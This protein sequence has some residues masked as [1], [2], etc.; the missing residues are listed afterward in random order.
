MEEELEELE[1]DI[2]VKIFSSGPGVFSR[3]NLPRIKNGT[4]VI[5]LKDVLKI[6]MAEEISLEFRLRKTD[7]TRNY[8]LDE[9]KHNNLM[10][11][12]YRNTCKYLNYVEHFLIIASTVT[13]CV[14]ISAFASLVCVPVGIT[15]SAVEINVSSITAG[16]KRYKPI[17]KKRKKKHDKIV[18][19]GK[20]KLNTVE[21][22]ISKASIDLYIGHDKFVSVNTVLREYYE[23]KKEINKS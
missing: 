7:E 1:E 5:N 9:I 10:S 4:Y 23:M 22:L 16:I 18:L 20:D 14:S 11:E 3:D 8:L 19:L 17:K 2:W 15:S 21:V 6:N 12:K 13:D